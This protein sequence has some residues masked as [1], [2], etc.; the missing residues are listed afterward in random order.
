MS[1]THP[2]LSAMGARIPLQVEVEQLCREQAP[3]RFA[4]CE[5]DYAADDALILA[6]GYSLD[7]GERVIVVGEAGGPRFATFR[8]IDR[9]KR[10]FGRA[11]DVHLVWID[12]P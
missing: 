7:G 3:R 4:I 6:W 12:S 2:V 10:V 5:M 8:S 9:A 11:T 1:S